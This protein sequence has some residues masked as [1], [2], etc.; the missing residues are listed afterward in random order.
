MD[1][2]V[3]LGRH[4]YTPP[5]SELANTPD[6]PLVDEIWQWWGSEGQRWVDMLQT[7]T[8]ETEIDTAVK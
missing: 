7:T 8:T 5:P 4:A 6:S 3:S 2:V 1:H